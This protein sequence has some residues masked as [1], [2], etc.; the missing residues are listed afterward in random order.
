[1]EGAGVELFSRLGARSY[2][3]VGRRGFQAANHN[4]R[5]WL[6]SCYSSHL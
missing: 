5:L 3:P 2:E 4:N 6:P 1:M